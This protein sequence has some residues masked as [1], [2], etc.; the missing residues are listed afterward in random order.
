MRDDDNY[1]PFSEIT[2][3]GY[4]I[5]GIASQLIILTSDFKWMQSISSKDITF[6]SIKCS[7][8]DSTLAL[9][10]DESFSLLSPDMYLPHFSL[11]SLCVSA[12]LKHSDIL[13]AT[14][15]PVGLQRLLMAHIEV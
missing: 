7:Q 13:L 5:V 10:G 14:Y 1:F 15:L 11:S 3:Q 12:V 8:L 9:I 6:K 2:K 4:I